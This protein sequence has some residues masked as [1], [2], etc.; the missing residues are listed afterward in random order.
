MSVLPGYDLFRVFL[1]DNKRIKMVFKEELEHMILT[2]K[3]FDYINDTGDVLEFVDLPPI[4]MMDTVESFLILPISD[5]S[6]FNLTTNTAK[7]HEA[8]AL[9]LWCQWHL[10]SLELLKLRLCGDWEHAP[11]FNTWWLNVIK[12]YSGGFTMSLKNYVKYANGLLKSRLKHDFL[13]Y[14]VRATNS[15]NY[16]NGC[17]SVSSLHSM[18]GTT[19]NQGKPSEWHKAIMK[20]RPGQEDTFKVIDYTVEYFQ[21]LLTCRLNFNLLTLAV[22]LM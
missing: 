16:Y 6:K 4:G 9:I 5:F 18:K 12:N 11:S 17:M 10:W 13:P 20:E 15:A 2:D 1:E 8:E 14:K 21:I 19:T 22:H 3:Q 7:V